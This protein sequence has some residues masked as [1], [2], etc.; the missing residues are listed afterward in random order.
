MLFGGEEATLRL[1]VYSAT[2]SLSRGYLFRFRL[3]LLGIFCKKSFRVKWL[4]DGDL[5]RSNSKLLLKLSW[6]RMTDKMDNVVV[7]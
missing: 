6:F 7:Y 4:R 3:P 5:N 2:C 1:S